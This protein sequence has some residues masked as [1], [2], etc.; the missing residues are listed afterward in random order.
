[1]LK[2]LV[3][4]YLY[5]AKRLP[6]EVQFVFGHRFILLVGNDWKP[7]AHAE[8]VASIENWLKDYARFVLTLE[9]LILV[10]PKPG[11]L[12]C[13]NTRCAS[14]VRAQW[15]HEN[16]VRL[17]AAAFTGVGDFCTLQLMLTDWPEKCKPIE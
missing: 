11:E 4:E 17:V 15:T 1:M 16:I 6:T 12:A 13:F 8:A 14:I 3:I 5:E 10:S 2:S 7:I 9:D